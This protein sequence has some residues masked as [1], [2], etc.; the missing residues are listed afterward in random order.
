MLYTF[1]QFEL[2]LGAVE[3]RADGQ[4]V[5]LEPQVFALLTLLVQNRDRLVSR[6]ELIEKV[7]DGRIVSDAAVASRV[8]SAR[9]ALGDDG[10][11]QRFIKTIHGRGYRFVAQARAAQ[12]FVGVSI[13][14]TARREFPDLGQ[15]VQR[16][17]RL[18]RPSLAVLPFRF[19]R[20]MH[21]TPTR[22]RAS[23]RADHR[24]GAVALALCH[25][26]RLVLSPCEVQE[27]DFRDIGR[28]L[29]VRYSDG[30]G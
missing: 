21:D 14:D 23:R 6:D 12:S 2:D 27:A 8:K 4:N 24:P 18:S 15:V 16:L 22:Q 17:G 29:H 19:E 20:A 30:S 11:S 3:L 1:G 10:K 28:L 7:W 26:A 5:D 13:A 25:R 9:Q